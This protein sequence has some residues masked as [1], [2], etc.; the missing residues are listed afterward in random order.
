MSKNLVIVESPAK[1]K[2]IEK[3]LGKDY[4]VLSSQG[5]IRDIEKDGK[6]SIGIDFEHG[7]APHYAIDEQKQHLIQTLRSEVKKSDKVW[8]ASD[9]DREGEAIAWHLQQVLSLPDNEPNRIVF[10]EI[11]KT[12][13][14]EAIAHPRSIDYNLVNAQQ[15]RRVVDRIVGYELSPVLWRKVTSGLSA[16]RVQSVAVRLIVEREREIQNF[17]ST[18]QYRV[19]ADFAGK[20]ADGKKTVLHTELNH[21]FAT[22]Q[23]AEQ[24][25]QQCKDAIFTI[26][27]ISHKPTKRTPAPP[28]TTSTLQQEASRKLH[29]SV[30]RTMRLA[31]ALYEAGHITYMRTD[32]VNLSSLAINTAREAILQSFGEEYHKARQYHTSTKGAQEA[33]EAIRPTFITT[34]VAGTTAEQKR[35][36]DLIRKRTLACQMADATIENTRIEITTDQ[37]PYAFVATGEV[38][39]FD[40][41]MRAYVQTSDDEETESTKALPRMEENTLMQTQMIQARQ[42]FTKAPM[43]FTEASLVKRMEELGI[44]RPSTYATTIETIQQRNYVQKGD[45]QGKKRSVDTLILQ[46]GQVAAQ[47]QSETYGQDSQKLLPTDLGQLTNDFLVQH[48]PEILNYDFT[49]KEE[50]QFDRVAEGKADWVKTV[51]TFYK[52]FHPAI[53]RVPKGK[54][55]ARLLGNDPKTG[56]PVYAK[57]SK[58]GPCIQIGTAEGDKPRFASLQPNQS[59]FTITLEEAL[60]LFEKQPKAALMQIDGKDVTAGTGRFGPYIRYDGQFFSIPKGKT[61]ESLTEADIRELMAKKAEQQKPIHVWGDVQVLQGRYGPYIKDP[62]GNYRIPKGTDVEAMTE[63]ECIRLI[64]KQKGRSKK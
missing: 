1:A 45:V 12:A 48:F 59:L 27:A 3:F 55:D 29:F 31:Q 46:D 51:D 28:F 4:H 14:Q 26:S 8:L 34:E 42:S 61:A 6:N 39:L 63:D 7:Y 23:E 21:R 16:G 13:I 41:F 50:E 15:A 40:G 60:Q 24:F 35:L 64:T 18:A 54:M 57:V 10:H 33:H 11:T 19:T 25:L 37:S 20:T 2:T 62:S 47:S 5:H 43:R 36:Y 44:G 22:R 38:V 9:E 56:E 30:S 32:S 52:A 17:E 49:A 53:E 58:L